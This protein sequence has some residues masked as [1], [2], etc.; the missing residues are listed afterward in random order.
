MVPEF[1]HCS[2]D[3]SGNFRADRSPFFIGAHLQI[4][5]ILSSFDFGIH[6]R[7]LNW[8]RNPLLGMERIDTTSGQL[9]ISDDE[10]SIFSAF[11]VVI[12]LAAICLST[13]Y[14]RLKFTS[15]M[16]V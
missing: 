3:R 12:V 15:F 11:A 8:I 5:A 7:K 6:I 13:A 1:L 14:Q 4:C 16:G 9:Q 10:I 2:P